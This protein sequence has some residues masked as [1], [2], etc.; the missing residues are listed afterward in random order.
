MDRCCA[1]AGDVQH[2]FCWGAG[3]SAQLIA[4]A[5]SAAAPRLSLA[6]ASTGTVLLPSQMS[7]TAGHAQHAEGSGTAFC[8]LRGI[9][10]LHTKEFFFLQNKTFKSNYLK[11]LLC[12]PNSAQHL[13]L[14][15]GNPVR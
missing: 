4:I 10:N 13:E 7:Q 15:L 1:P 8:M 3:R 12:S 6:T 9:N 2:Y 14:A 5:A 11:Y